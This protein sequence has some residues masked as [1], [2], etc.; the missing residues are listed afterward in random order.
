LTED[1]STHQQ[2]V[3]TECRT[4]SGNRLFARFWQPASRK[5]SGCVII[6]HGLGEHGGRYEPV[7][8]RLAE[9][10]WA[11]LV[12]DLQGHGLSPGRRGHATS[13][14]G[15]LQDIHAMRKTASQCLPDS[16]QV[17]LGHSMGGNLAT[18]Y[19]L[20]HHQHHQDL[21][22]LLGLVL[23]G[24][25]FL[26]TNPP[27]RRQI[28]AAWLTGH[29]IPWLTI[30]MPVDINKLTRNPETADRIRK[31]KLAHGRISLY[32]ATQLLAQG[33]YALDHAHEI[34]VPTL[35]M[36]GSEDPITSYRA[37]ESFSIRGG[38]IVK[39]FAFPG[40]LHEIFHETNS[41]PVYET[42]RSWLQDRIR[43]PER[44]IPTKSREI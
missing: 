3:A 42:M 5:A 43:A 23:S 39:F 1:S 28:F 30:R 12:A 15:L 4:G 8:K 32:V 36:H 26:P 34:N 2:V 6:V 31:D 38:D 33:R 24:P 25:M 37:S 10:G 13:Y 18:N 21:D 7:V 41:D 14:F 29:V 19:V 35:I 17:L 11:S 40:M 9:Y 20:R 16:P 22:P 44:L 27:D